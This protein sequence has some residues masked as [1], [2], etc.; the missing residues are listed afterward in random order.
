MNYSQQREKIDSVIKLLSEDSSTLAKV[1][2]VL[3][4]MRGVDARLDKKLE[5]V[6]RAL[7][8]LKNVQEGDVLALTLGN[9]PEGTE[10]EK[11]RK[12]A[13]IL[14]IK[15]WKD[16]RDEVERVRAEIDSASGQGANQQVASFAKV[17]AFAKGPFGIVTL[18]ALVIAIALV[19]T[20]RGRTQT[21]PLTVATTPT[22]SPSASLTP[23]PVV[24]PSPVGKTKIQVITYNGKKIPLDMLAVRT[25]PDCTNSPTEAPHYHAANG[26]YVFAT[27]GTRIN[28]PGACAFGK[29]SETQVEQISPGDNVSE[30]GFDRTAF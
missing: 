7:A 12:K 16:L 9:L 29:V 27:D 19:F 21:Q 20:N 4:L 1:E 6:N 18:I 28:D 3:T 23:S 15:T 11:K 17:A 26:Q 30:G 14:F 22:P 10:K 2:K 24:S 25:G 5:S 8:T 13:L